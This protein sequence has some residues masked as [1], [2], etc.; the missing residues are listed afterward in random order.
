[1]NT[2]RYS[3]PYIIYIAIFAIFPFVFTFIFAGLHFS[4]KSI[5]IIPITEIVK[6][7][8]IFSVFTAVFATVVGYFLAIVA[9]MLTRRWAR[10]FSLFVILPFTIPFTASALIWSISLYGG[11]YGWFTY[12]LHIAYDPLYFPSTAI[13]GVTLVSIWTSIPFAF[14]II[15]SAFKSIPQEVVESSQ[16]DGLKLSEYYFSVANPLIG[17]AFWT[18]FILN[19]VLSLGNF[20]LPYVMTGGGPGYASTTLPLIVYEEFFI[21][22]NVP[23]GAFFAAILSIIATIPSI[24]LLYAIKEKRSPMPSLRIRLNDEMFKIILGAFS[25]VVLFFLDMPIYWMIIVSIRSPIED[26]IS[27]PDFFPTKI[28]MSFLVDAARDSIPYMISSI[29]VSLAVALITIF[30][31]SAASFEITK[32]KRLSFLLP[33]SIYFYSLPSASYIIPVY[34]MISFLGLLNTW[35]GLILASPVFTATYSVWLMYNF[36]SVMPKSYEEAA[37]VFGI[38]NKFFRIILPLSRPVLISSFLLSFIFSWH[39]LF[40]PLVLTY[41]PYCMNFPPQGSETV[42]IFALNAIGDLTINWG[43][44]ASSALISSIPVLIVAWYAIDRVIKGAYKGGL[45]FV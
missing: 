5:G 39:L 28:D 34:L 41:T 42:T 44:L 29:V 27:P 6:N 40:Y 36:F 12:L 7:T 19:F 17:K 22:D 15:F 33:L 32:S 26:F 1:M 14:L 43:E 20:D 2:L 37:D 35:W 10:L 25:A 30:I 31:S 16:V 13:Y 9:D 38:K 24:G 21:L 45:K 8:F 3:I 18:A 23:A 4:L 11:G